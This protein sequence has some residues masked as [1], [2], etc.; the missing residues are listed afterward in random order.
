MLL[1]DMLV[2]FLIAVLSGL[3]IGSGGLLILYLT[4][5][6][7][8]PQVIAQGYNLLF[9]LFAAAS[10]MCVHL[11]RRSIRLPAVAL[12]ISAG[13]PCSYFGAQL[14]LRL[15]EGIM[16]RLFGIFLVLAGT[17]GVLGHSQRKKAEKS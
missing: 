7:H 2:T 3:G 14:A 10:S 16:T 5:V 9:F 17:Q 6:R 8:A 13:L 15:P 1:V 4:L 12:M 11:S